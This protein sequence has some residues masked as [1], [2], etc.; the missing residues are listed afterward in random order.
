MYEVHIDDLPEQVYQR[1]KEMILEGELSAGQ[2]LV[3]EDLAA[4]L[5]VSRTPL[6]TAFRKLEK[7]MLV[8]LIPRRGAFVRENTDDDLLHIFDI[9]LKIEPLAARDATAA[10][11]DEGLSIIIE[12][13]DRFAEAVE[14]GDRIR[15]RRA[16]YNFHYAIMEQSGNPFIPLM[17]SSV[18]LISISNVSGL[19]TDPKVSL[20]GHQSILAAIKSRNPD[21]AEEAMAYHLNLSRNTLLK[22]RNEG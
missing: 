17:L 3:Q 13:H 20:E 7:E 18:N 14:A 16:D 19:V 15:Y 6:L 22:H 2:K 5:G 12:K 8:Q 9:R 1:I 4:Q 21:A 10:M 11:T